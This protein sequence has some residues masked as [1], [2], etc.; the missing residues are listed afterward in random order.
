LAYIPI[1]ISATGKIPRDNLEF[2]KPNS[3][4]HVI[5]PRLQASQAAAVVSH[6]RANDPAGKA[7]R[8]LWEDILAN[9]NVL[10]QL[11]LRYD[12]YEGIL[13]DQ[14][15]RQRALNALIGCKSNINCDA[16]VKFTNSVN[17]SIL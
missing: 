6:R 5:L 9:K 2:G 14:S 3:Q 1:L 8:N 12:V 17:S 10:K 13:E 4:F 16:Q 11:G 7:I 15:E